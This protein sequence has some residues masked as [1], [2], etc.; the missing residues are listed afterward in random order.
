MGI[1]WCIGRFENMYFLKLM[2]VNKV[3]VFGKDF[4]NWVVGKEDDDFIW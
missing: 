2:E 3:K 4:M 1:F